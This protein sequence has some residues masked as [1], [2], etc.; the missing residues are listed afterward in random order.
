ALIAPDAE[1]RAKSKELI[2][3]DR[4][5]LIHCTASLETCQQRDPRGHYADAADGKIP[6]LPGDGSSYDV[7]EAADLVLDTETS[8]VDECVESVIEM[9]R[10]K[11]VIR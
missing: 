2:G 8:T 1:I 7:P 6:A 10:D 11:Q 4:F 5:Y 9:L 3:E